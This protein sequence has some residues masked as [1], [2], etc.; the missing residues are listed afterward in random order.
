METGVFVTRPLS[1]GCCSFAHARELGFE[2][3]AIRTRLALQDNPSQ[4]CATA[5]VIAKTRLA[6]VDQRINSL[7]ALKVE[8]ELMV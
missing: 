8:L 5:G 2:I 4:S 7:V 6:E 3:D 1:G